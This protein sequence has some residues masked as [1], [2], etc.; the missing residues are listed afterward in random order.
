MINLTKG[1]IKIICTFSSG[2]KPFCMFGFEFS[3]RE[4]FWKPFLEVLRAYFWLSTQCLLLVGLWGPCVILGMELKLA[5]GA[6]PT[7]LSLCLLQVF[8]PFQKILFS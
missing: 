7:V 8:I 1:K 2:R 4:T 3:F 6:L 5:I